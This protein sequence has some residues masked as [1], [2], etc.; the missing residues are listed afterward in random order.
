M[1]AQYA[2]TGNRMGCGFGVL[3]VYLYTTFYGFCLDVTSYVYCAEIF[4]T[5]MRTT[6]MAVS[7]ISYFAP[8]LRMLLHFSASVVS[9]AINDLL[10]TKA[11]WMSNSLR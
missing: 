6:G 4:P 7:I 2:G 1:V 10:L 3:F 11:F 8:A 9:S 5:Y